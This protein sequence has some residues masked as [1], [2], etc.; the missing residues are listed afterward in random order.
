MAVLIKKKHFYAVKDIHSADG[1]DMNIDMD[2]SNA[3]SF[4][5]SAGRSISLQE[6][7]IFVTCFVLDT[8]KRWLNGNLCMQYAEGSLACGYF[9][10]S[11]PI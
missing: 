2:Q 6:G 9:T 5:A 8:S 7:L 11:N 1:L 3:T 4:Y 10:L